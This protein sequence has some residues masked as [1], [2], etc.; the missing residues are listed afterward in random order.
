MTLSAHRH[1]QIEDKALITEVRPI[2]R[3]RR[4]GFSEKAFGKSS[5]SGSGS[6]KTRTLVS[7]GFSPHLALHGSPRRDVGRRSP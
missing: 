7:V 2:P 3:K 5:A 1:F 6:E 4:T